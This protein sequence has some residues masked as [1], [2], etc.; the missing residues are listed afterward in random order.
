MVL[1]IHHI[2]VIEPRQ[3]HAR[4]FVDVGDET[5]TVDDLVAHYGEQVD[6]SE[7]R[8]PA[9]LGLGRV[10]VGD[11]LDALAAKY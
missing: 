1:E 8:R 6:L 4:A 3:S 5:E 9:A 10:N 2:N 7:L 11:T